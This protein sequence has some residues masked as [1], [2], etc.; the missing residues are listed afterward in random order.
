MSGRQIEDL[1]TNNIVIRLVT[2]ATD[3]A[4]ELAE[5]GKKEQMYSGTQKYV[6]LNF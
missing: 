2:I 6:T 4:R 1:A 5:R 3:R